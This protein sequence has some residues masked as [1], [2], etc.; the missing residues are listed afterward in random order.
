MWMVGLRTCP[1]WALK[2]QS[3][4]IFEDFDNFWR[5]MYTKWLQE[6]SQ[7]LEAIPEITLEGPCVGTGYD[8]LECRMW[9]GG[10]ITCSPWASMR[11]RASS[12]GTTYTGFARI[13]IFRIFILSFI[14][15]S[16][17]RIL[18]TKALPSIRSIHAYIRP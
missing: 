13:F 2:P 5:S 4:A 1:P 7:F 12:R 16:Y 15:I 11:R 18:C 10:L 6:R 9:L 14:R 3:K 8:P 17:I